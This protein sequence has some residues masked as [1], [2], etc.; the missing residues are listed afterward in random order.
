MAVA[1]AP[2]L[3]PRGRRGHLCSSPAARLPLLPSLTAARAGRHQA[4]SRLTWRS[5]LAV[6]AQAPVPPRPRRLSVAAVPVVLVPVVPQPLRTTL[7]TG[8]RMGSLTLLS[9]QCLPRFV[10]LRVAT[11]PVPCLPPA[12]HPTF[13]SPQIPTHTPTH[14]HARTPSLGWDSLPGNDF[15][16]AAPSVSRPA[17]LVRAYVDVW[18]P[19]RMPFQSP[20]SSTRSTPVQSRGDDHHGDVKLPSYQRRLLERRAR[21]SAAG[22]TAPTNDRSD[23]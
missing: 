20:L 22:A 14:P 23:N 19:V 7:M 16:S 5:T 10:A 17:S 8:T 13:T 3:A 18:A 11:P 6:A 1:R 4:R 2:L 12:R 15:G 9:R 21:Y